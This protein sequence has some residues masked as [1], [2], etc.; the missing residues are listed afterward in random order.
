MKLPHE[1]CNHLLNYYKFIHQDS[2]VPREFN[3]GSSKRPMAVCK[4]QDIRFGKNF[5]EIGW[6][7]LEMETIWAAYEQSSGRI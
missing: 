7:R 4:S 6:T 3:Y 2:M 1:L 5:F